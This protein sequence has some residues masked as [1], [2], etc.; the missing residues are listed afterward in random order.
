LDKTFVAVILRFGEEAVFNYLHFY[1]SGHMTD[2]GKKIKNLAILTQEAIE[3][4]P[5][6]LLLDLQ[7]LKKG[8]KWGKAKSKLMRC[9]IS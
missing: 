5:F 9:E 3:G 8:D 7:Q 1:G 6:T 2:K 4:T